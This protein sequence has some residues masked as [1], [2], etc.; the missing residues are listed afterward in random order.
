[1]DSFVGLL[2]WRHADHHR[3][4]LTREWNRFHQ[5]WTEDS[6]RE[7][8]EFGQRSP[9]IERQLQHNIFHSTMKQSSMYWKK[10]GTEKIIVNC[11]LFL[12]LNNKSTTESKWS[13]P[14]T[15]NAG[16]SNAEQIWQATRLTWSSKHSLDS[17]HQNPIKDSLNPQCYCYLAKNV[18]F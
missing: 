17:F 18:V 13:N 12:K 10:I 16:L 15:N 9:Q 5:E 1:M 14:I 7:H 2:F 11:P 8:S 3:Q 6:G 4:G